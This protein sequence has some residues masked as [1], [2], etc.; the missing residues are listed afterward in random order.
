MT[1]ALCRGCLP[2][3]FSKRNPPPIDPAARNLCPV[4]EQEKVRSGSLPIVE[5]MV[6]GKVSQVAMF[7][8]ST[9]P[10]EGKTTNGRTQWLPRSAL[11]RLQ[12]SAHSEMSSER[13]FAPQGN[14]SWWYPPHSGTRTRPQWW[15]NAPD[16]CTGLYQ[17]TFT[18]D[19]SRA[20]PPTK[21]RDKSSPNT[22]PPP[23]RGGRWVPPG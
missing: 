3:N 8:I 21:K 23:R 10:L 20:T 7:L 5:G 6:S 1:S 16:C 17:Q 4:K 13:V 14:E 19:F 15:G 22:T 18:T 12:I 11:P 9:P 2:C